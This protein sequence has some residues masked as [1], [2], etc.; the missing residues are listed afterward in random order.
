MNTNVDIKICLAGKEKII[1]NKLENLIKKIGKSNV[2]YFPHDLFN[3]GA[4]S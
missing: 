2:L 3:Y 4:K 1:F